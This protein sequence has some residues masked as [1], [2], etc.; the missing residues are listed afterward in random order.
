MNALPRR[1]TSMLFCLDGKRSSMSFDDHAKAVRFKDL[2]N[3]VGPADFHNASRGRLP[4]RNYPPRPGD[5]VMPVPTSLHCVDARPGVDATSA[6][7]P[8]GLAA[9]HCSQTS[10]AT[11]DQTCLFCARV[12]RIES[13]W[14]TIVF[15]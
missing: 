6:P 14:C 5:A 11:L 9:D 10:A 12:P 13:A 3:Q 15:T 4:S 1:Y 8:T 2:V 7:R